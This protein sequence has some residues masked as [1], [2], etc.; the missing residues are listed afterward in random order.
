MLS[1]CSSCGRSVPPRAQNPAY[2]FCSPHCK[3][4]DLGHWLNET[5]RIS[6]PDASAV[7]SDESAGEREEGQ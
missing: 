3:Q 2:P 7:P 6:D 5:Y 4:A 1:R